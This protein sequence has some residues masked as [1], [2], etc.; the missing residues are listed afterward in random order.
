MTRTP[1]EAGLT[2]PLPRRPIHTPS[3]QQGVSLK[4]VEPTAAS[5]AY[6]EALARAAILRGGGTGPRSEAG[7]RAASESMKR[8]AV[9]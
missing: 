4:R 3:L 2:R 5:K 8:P 7:G 6:E 1:S 9:E